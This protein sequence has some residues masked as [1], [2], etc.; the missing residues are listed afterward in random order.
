MRS[1]PEYLDG[2]NKYSLAI[3]KHLDDVKNDRFVYK[4]HIYLSFEK[5]VIKQASE[6][7]FNELVADS[8]FKI[9]V[10]DILSLICLCL[11]LVVGIPYT[12]H[13]MKA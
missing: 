1:T 2:N 9:F 4:K 7:S 6:V 13:I 11:V 3:Y 8:I 10:T 5:E 12:L